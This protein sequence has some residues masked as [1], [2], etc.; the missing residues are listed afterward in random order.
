MINEIQHFLIENNKVNAVGNKIL[1]KI[2]NKA[3]NLLFELE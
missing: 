1:L 2:N 3:F